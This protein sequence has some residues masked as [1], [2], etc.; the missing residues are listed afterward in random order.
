VLVS[1]ADELLDR[2]LETGDPAV[3]ARLRREA[4]AERQTERQL[5]REGGRPHEVESPLGETDLA[6]AALA[7]A[8]EKAEGPELVRLG[9]RVGAIFGAVLARLHGA[10]RLEILERARRA[11]GGGR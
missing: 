1:R 7:Q 9:D 5:A 11:R 10:P 6:I 4:D 2:A 3:A 8:V